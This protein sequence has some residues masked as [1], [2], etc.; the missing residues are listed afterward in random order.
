MKA[1]KQTIVWVDRKFSPESPIMQR[2]CASIDHFKAQGWTI[3]VWCSSADSDFSK[4]ADKVVKILAGPYKLEGITRSFMLMTTARLWSEKMRGRKGVI[5]HA[6]KGCAFGADISSHNFSGV[7]W[8]KIFFKLKHKLA[9]D[10]LKI[11]MALNAALWESIEMRFFKAEVIIANSNG[12]RAKLIKRYGYDSQSCLFVKNQINENRFSP[13]IRNQYREQSRADLNFGRED[14]VFMFASQGHMA[15]KGWFDAVFSIENL[16]KRSGGKKSH[17]LVVGFNKKVKKRA[18]D[19][20][21]ENVNSWEE[22]IHFIEPTKKLEYFLSASD[23]FLFPSYF[24]SCANVA[25]EACAMGLPCVLGNYFGADLLAVNKQ[26]VIIENR[27]S[28]DLA[29]VLKQTQDQYEECYD[30]E[31]NMKPSSCSPEEWAETISDIYKKLIKGS[32]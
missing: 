22:W 24:D 4:K 15:R 2:F 19:F 11:P 26:V 7:E 32:R 3:E 29:N 25:Q 14:Y 21:D 13:E 12:L 10:W 17:L 27:D 6:T 5:Y 20:L 31:V 23:C 18:Q 8:L 1:D 30:M 16:R 9:S 28:D